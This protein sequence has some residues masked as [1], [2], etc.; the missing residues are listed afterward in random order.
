MRKGK[1]IILLGISTSGKTY[2]KEK[3]I[4][5]FSLYQLRRVV[6]RPRR[7]SEN[8]SMDINV[9]EEQFKIMKKQNKFFVDTKINQY[10][11]GYLKEDFQMA[12]EKNVIGDCYYKLMNE[13]RKKLDDRVVIICL[14]PYDLKSTIKKIV[15]EREDYKKRIKDAKKEYKFY[16][17]NKKKIDFMI[18]T[19][20]SANT[21]EKVYKIVNEILK[22]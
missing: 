11:Y 20:Y 22:K 4:K 3:L 12:S 1:I 9:S 10:Y 13:L 16:N 15:R 7:K 18:Y 5:R 17:K 19:D 21:D 2:Y 8:N 14:Q 6:T